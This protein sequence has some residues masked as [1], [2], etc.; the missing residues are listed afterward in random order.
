MSES[1][2]RDSH[3]ASLSEGRDVIDVERPPPSSYSCSNFTAPLA[4]LPPHTAPL[5]FTWKDDADAWLVALHGSW[6]SDV[7]VGYKVA[8]PA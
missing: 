2:T 8:F 4:L 7:P 6:N 5:G 3:T 1:T